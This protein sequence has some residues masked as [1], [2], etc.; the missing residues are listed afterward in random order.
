MYGIGPA[1]PR[2]LLTGGPDSE[3]VLACL[4]PLRRQQNSQAGAWR[5]DPGRA[6]EFSA[7]DLR[8][9]AGAQDPLRPV[10][11]RMGGLG[12]VHGGIENVSVE[13]RSAASLCR[14]Y[15]QVRECLARVGAD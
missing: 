9:A 8:V 14:L 2:G 5:R 10:L 11:L 7:L 1:G 6:E 15:L 3:E 12:G 13:G 4:V